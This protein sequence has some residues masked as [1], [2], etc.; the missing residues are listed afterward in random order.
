MI[1]GLEYLVQ[2]VNV[3]KA[4]KTK[5][6]KPLTKAEVKRIKKANPIMSKSVQRRLRVQLGYPES[7][8]F[9]L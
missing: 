2:G 3:R 8:S 9:E 1:R 6:A 5:A 7:E 4:A